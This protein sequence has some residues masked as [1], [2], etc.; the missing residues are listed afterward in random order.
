MRDNPLICI[1]RNNINR[2]CIPLFLIGAN[3]PPKEDINMPN[4]SNINFDF[5]NSS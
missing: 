3:P 4:S 2:R 5:T 1:I